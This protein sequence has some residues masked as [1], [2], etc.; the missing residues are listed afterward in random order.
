MNV[1][2]Q[3]SARANN[4]FDLHTKHL[5]CYVACESASG[6]PLLQVAACNSSSNC[7]LRPAAYKDMQQHDSS[8]AFLL[9]DVTVLSHDHASDSAGPQATATLHVAT[10]A[11]DD[12]E[13]KPTRL[14]ALHRWVVADAF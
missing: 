7:G 3:H 9:R 11:A 6:R 1:W 5:T 4:D 2:L 14:L 10:P 13:Q 12:C 8:T